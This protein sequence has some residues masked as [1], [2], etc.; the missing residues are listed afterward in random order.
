MGGADVHAAGEGDSTI[1]DQ[2]LAVIAQIDVQ[3]RRPQA[4]RVVAH[5]R[6]TARQ[7]LAAGATPGQ[8]ADAIEQA[9]HGHAAR[10]GAVQRFD[11]LL[12]GFV[13][14]EDVRGQRDRV[15][16]SID[17]GEHPRVG[18]FTVVQYLQP[19]AG[20]QRQAGDHVA[21]ARYFIEADRHHIGLVAGIALGVARATARR[22]LLL[23]LRAGEHP[24][25]AEHEVQHRPGKRQQQAGADPAP[26]RRGVVLVQQGVRRRPGGQQQAGDRQQP[27]ADL[28]DIGDQETS[29]GC[30]RTVR[31]TGR[32]SDSRASS[33]RTSWTSR[34]SVASTWSMQRV[35]AQAG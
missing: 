34:P 24:V 26:G 28:A 7:Q 30:R 9:A 22:R 29:S 16:R 6:H 13:A 4:Q 35:G 3:E 1:D 17:R 32:W 11:E 21:A 25:D 2:Q 18:R 8:L 10:L 23:A 31:P 27:A 5:H 14:I 15:L 33:T 12:A 19:V 20:Q